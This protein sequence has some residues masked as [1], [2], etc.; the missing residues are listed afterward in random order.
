MVDATEQDT[1]TSSEDCACQ[2]HTA[3][4]GEVSVREP[5]P[6]VMAI[7]PTDV[8]LDLIFDDHSHSQAF[9]WSDVLE[10]QAFNRDVLPADEVRLAFRVPS[11][12]YEFGDMDLGF[13]QLCKELE[14]KFPNIPKGWFV[15]VSLPQF[16]TQRRI[17][18]SATGRLP[19]WIEF[20]NRTMRG[21]DPVLWNATTWMVAAFALAFLLLILH[22][23][24]RIPGPLI[25]FRGDVV[26]CLLM[27][28]V[29][30]RGVYGWS[31]TTVIQKIIRFILVC[32]AAALLAIILSVVIEHVW[33]RYPRGWLLGE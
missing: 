4:I 11:G 32:A 6:K 30:I 26:P 22:P 2:W 28:V 31:S 9:A 24:G 10:I 20:P 8:G 13:S 1:L 33:L 18:F 27:I 29:M 12:W 25:S 16:A 21:A 5:K 15:E 14:K 17:L 3:K 19:E 7:E 23:D